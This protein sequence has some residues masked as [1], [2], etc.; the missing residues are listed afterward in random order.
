MQ[1]GR[2]SQNEKAKIA[3]SYNKLYS[4]FSSQELKEVGNYTIIKLIGEGSFGKVY[5]ANH[6]LTH[7]KVVL[8]TGAKDDP[9][10][11]REVYYHRQFQHPN[12]TRLYE[13][14]I[15][16]GLIWMVL[17]YCPGK[18]LYDYVLS[19]GRIPI[20]EVKKL[21]AQ[22]TIA[23]YYAHSLNCIHRDLKLENI[24]LDKK[25]NAKLSDFGFTREY[26]SHKLLDTICGTTVYMAPELI[27]KDKYNGFRVDIWSLGIILYT[28]LYGEMPFDED[29]EMAT[30]YKIINSEPNYKDD[31]PKDAIIL[32]QKLL[33]KNPGLR[34]LT[35]EILSDPFLENYGIQNL[36]IT[37]GLIKTLINQKFFQSKIEKHLLKKLKHLGIDINQ[38]Q[39]SVINKNCDSLCGLWELLLEKQKKKENKRYKT[40]SS[41]TVLRLTESTSRRVSQFMDPINSPPIS[42]IVSL[43][44][45]N[46]T[47][48]YNSSIHSTYT[49]ANTTRTSQDNQRYN[50]ALENGKISGGSSSFDNNSLHNNG[51]ISSP[52]KKKPGFL[53]KLSKLW[54]LNN[55]KKNDPMISNGSFNHTLKS[56][57]SFNNSLNSGNNLNQSK[58]NGNQH[59]NKT[60]PQF[61]EINKH[62]DNDSID[63]QSNPLNNIDKTKSTNLTNSTIV[64]N[65]PHQLTIREPTSPL[66]FISKKS[67][68]S[69]PKSSSNK[70]PRPTSMI[71][72]HSIASQFTTN[73][74][75]SLNSTQSESTTT[76]PSFNR[77]F[78]SDASSHSNKNGSNNTGS[79]T[80]SGTRRSLSLI[81]SNSSTSDRSSRKSSFY[82]QSSSNSFKFSSKFHHSI[83]ASSSLPSMN[84]RG[85]KYNE[86][87][88]FPKS[89]A[90]GNVRRKKSPLSTGLLP[91]N[92]NKKTKSFILEEDEF[93]EECGNL[94]DLDLENLNINDINEIT[95]TSSIDSENQR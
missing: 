57:N 90:H 30:K 6:K 13:V 80:G 65:Q 43:K 27:Q 29:N 1:S 52:E 55:N 4:Q 24:L 44:S 9:N 31:I 76:R 16:E 14:V 15:S 35:L 63:N 87:A 40:R 10:L 17:E 81:S 50:D 82:D 94:A 38:L 32:I 33:Q 61:Q 54:K 26:E 3:E 23:V 8:K 58:L 7:T 37:N 68:K 53:N 85:K 20:D 66:R 95:R 64:S 71:S 59:H 22:I 28:L 73:S 51:S 79:A 48:N 36:E 41:R 2:T 25:R 47:N 19:M 75:L 89:L 78:S 49:R 60:I 42:R 77:G 62:S 70:L 34:P 83:S 92:F 18:E 11:V 69:S 39:K 84:R 86:G 12:I 74:E 93:D 67:S 46:T 45:S 21:F 88:I 5:L 56:Q 72:Q 91:S